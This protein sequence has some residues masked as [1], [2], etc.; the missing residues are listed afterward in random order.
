MASTLPRAASPGLP[1]RADRMAKGGLLAVRKADRSRRAAL[2]EV[3]YN[4][5]MIIRITRLKNQAAYVNRDPRQVQRWFRGEDPIPW[6]E[7][8]SI[9]ALQFPI[10][11]ALLESSQRDLVEIRTVITRRADAASPNFVTGGVDGE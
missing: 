8:L 4:A 2:G 10:M 7:L 9:K 3:L 1:E 11:Q 5:F 6:E